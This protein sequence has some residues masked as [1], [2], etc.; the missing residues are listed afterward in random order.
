MSLISLKLILIL[1]TRWSNTCLSRKDY[2]NESYNLQFPLYTEKN[3]Q[4]QAEQEL[5]RVRGQ[6]KQS[7]LLFPSIWRPYSKHL[8]WVSLLGNFC[9]FW[10]G[11]CSMDLTEPFGFLKQFSDSPK[12]GSH[13]PSRQLN[14]INS[15]VLSDSKSLQFKKTAVF[16]LHPET[17]TGLNLNLPF[18]G[19]VFF[20]F[21]LFQKQESQ[22]N[23]YRSTKSLKVSH[24]SNGKKLCF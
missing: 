9:L 16:N 5:F 17:R 3:L 4:A 15:K 2:R 10:V 18:M 6:E 20:Q 11:E 8:V 14:Q 21:I 22:D 19:Q 13:W 23:I 12:T 1:E 7:R 24:F